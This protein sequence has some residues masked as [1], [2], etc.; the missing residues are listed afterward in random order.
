MLLTLYRNNIN[1]WMGILHPH[2]Y[3]LIQT[4]HLWNSIPP[5]LFVFL[6][7][8]PLFTFLSLSFA[9]FSYCGYSYVSITKSKLQLSHI[10][11]K[12]IYFFWLA[13]NCHCF[14]MG[15]IMDFIWERGNKA[16]EEK[17][18][19][20]RIYCTTCCCCLVAQSRLT[21]LRPMGYSLRGSS[22]HGIFQA[23][24]LEWVA[25]SFSRGSSEPVSPTSVGKFLTTESQRKPIEQHKDP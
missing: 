22:V 7:E 17:Q 2:R 6:T 25:I 23:R 18:Q 5:C 11:L 3:A 13:A 15:Q 24:I 21:L 10:S 12:Y 4:Y 16:E 19:Y 20:R 9:S 14:Q 1:C 8:F